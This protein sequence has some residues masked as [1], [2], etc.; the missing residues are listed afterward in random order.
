MPAPVAVR[1]RA[2]VAEAVAAALLAAPSVGAVPR[3]GEAMPPVTVDGVDGRPRSFPDARVPVILFYEDK[4]AG[5]Q[6]QHVRDL[7]G[8][9]TDRADN[10]GRLELVPVADVEK[11]DFWPARKY[12]LDELRAIERRD[13]TRLWCDWKGRVRRAL[14]LTRG[15]SGVILVAPDGKIR[16]AHEGPLGDA[17]VRELLTRLAELG[18]RIK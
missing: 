7:L 17:H 15:R 8:P 5:L 16:F 6:N 18:V 13:A 1:V 11:W 12:V 4:D 9:I 3:A 2:P 10:R 14:G